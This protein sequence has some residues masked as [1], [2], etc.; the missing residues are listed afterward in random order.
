M[1]FNTKKALFKKVFKKIRIEYKGLFICMVFLVSKEDIWFFKIP[2]S[3]PDTGWPK[4][5]IRP[6]PNNRGSN[7]LGDRKC[8]IQPVAFLKK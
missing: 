3:R 4:I 6:N 5:T 2:T 1:I 8:Y 7:P